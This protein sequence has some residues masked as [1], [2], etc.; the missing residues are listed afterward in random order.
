ML[1]NMEIGADIHKVICCYFQRQVDPHVKSN[2]VIS[3]DD[4]YYDQI[5]HYNLY[6]ER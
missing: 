2:K 5:L 1:Y 4:D 6:R 3:C